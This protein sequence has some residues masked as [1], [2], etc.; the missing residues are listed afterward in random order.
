MSVR[1]SLICMALALL[2]LVGTRS[3]AASAISGA[4]Q[5]ICTPAPCAPAEGVAAYT[6]A[7]VS[8]GDGTTATREY[9]VWRPTNLVPSPQNRAPAVLVFYSA[10]NCGLQPSGRFASFAPSQRFVV[11]YMAAP[12]GRDNNWDKRNIDPA[13]STAVNDEPYVAAVVEAITQCPSSGA[14]LNQCVDPQR[15]YA[16]GTSSGGNM[17]ADVMCDAQSSPLFRAYLI[18]SS[19]LQLYEGAPACPSTNSHFFVMMALSNYGID[20]K[21]YYDTDVNPHLDVPAFADWAAARLGCTGRR[22][23][24]T[25]GYPLASTLRYT[26]SGPCAFALAGSPAV[27]TLGIQN[28][29][30]T[31]VCQDSDAGAQPNACPGMSNPPGLSSAG[32]PNT[33]GLFVE[34]EFWSFVAQGLSSEETPPAF[35]TWPPPT[36]PLEGPAATTTNPALEGPLATTAK[37][38][39]SPAPAAVRRHPAGPARHRCRP[40]VLHAAHNARDRRQHRRGHG[41]VCDRL[42]GQR[43]HHRQPRA[44]HMPA[45]CGGRK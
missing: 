19:S 13:T 41:C 12:C 42:L 27:V 18:D 26:Y 22:V 17:T 20:E 14:G 1:A 32:L 25:I 8:N 15:V 4:S 23:D 2:L 29:A 39:A 36:N 44:T 9:G 40:V 37:P 11:V 28:G 10:G 16:A 33:N 7:D 6:L 21:L 3:A 45:G 30:H 5:A 31:W 43:R 38:S 35:E 24:D 34:Q